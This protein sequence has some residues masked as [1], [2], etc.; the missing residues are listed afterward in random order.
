MFRSALFL[1]L[2]LLI[3]SA[4]SVVQW[5]G[6]APASSATSSQRS[7]RGNPAS[8]EVFGERYY[9]LNTSDGYKKRGV[10]SW[11]GKKFH[12][13]PTSSGEI[14]DMHDM[15]AA[16]KTLPL[17]VNA[18]V[19]NLENGRSVIVK[20]NDRGPFIDNRI[21]D[22]SYAAA[23]DL[24]MI[25]NGTALVEVETLGASLPPPPVQTATVVTGSTSPEVRRAAACCRYRQH[26]RRSRLCLA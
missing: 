20:I 2:L 21:I 9:I 15:T 25:T 10:A 1:L 23:R 8:Y 26:Q 17:P 7:S 6:D 5:G 4:C 14:Y 12:G 11:Y 3:M 19:T 22:L 16:H 13:K 24:D 18:K